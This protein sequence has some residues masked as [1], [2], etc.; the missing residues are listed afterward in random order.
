VFRVAAGERAR[1][2]KGVPH[3]LYNETDE[4]VVVRCDQEGD[5][6]PVEFAY[7]LSELYPLFNEKFTLKL[8]AK[9]AAFGS[10]FDSEMKGPPP[11]VFKAILRIIKP[12][13]RVF[14]ITALPAARPASVKEPMLEQNEE[15][16]A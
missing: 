9:I 4:E 13:A 6:L 14:G 3:R 12:Y 15:Q 10:M 2:P 1:I 16:V 8:L 7:A 5:H 11:I